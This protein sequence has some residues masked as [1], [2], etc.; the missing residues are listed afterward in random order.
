MKYFYLLLILF[1][2]SFVNAQNWQS[3]NYTLQINDDFKQESLSTQIPNLTEISKNISQNFEISKNMMSEI[4]GVE[5]ENYNSLIFEKA[6]NEAIETLL[7]KQSEIR[8]DIRKV[9]ILEAAWLKMNNLNPRLNTKM[10]ADIKEMKRI[11]LNSDS[12]IIRMIKFVKNL[13]ITDSNFI[14]I[15]KSSIDFNFDDKKYK[16]IQ[17]SINNEWTEYEKLN[18]TN[19]SSIPQISTIN[20][21]FN[22]TVSLLGAANLNIKGQYKLEVFVGNGAIDTFSTATILVPELSNYGIRLNGFKDLTK[23]FGINSDFHYHEKKSFNPHENVDFTFARIQSKLGIEYL[24]FKDILSVYGNVNFIIPVTNTEKYKEVFT[25]DNRDL[26]YYDLGLKLFVTPKGDLANT[27]G[28]G[29][30]VDLNFISTT[31][32]V[33]FYNGNSD[34]FIPNIK[35]GLQKNFR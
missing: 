18:K 10:F 30:F 13:E 23:R 5:N 15:E 28:V 9:D 22:P 21:K 12:E 33:K 16:E 20:K 31:E 4:K 7:F 11:L 14:P 27:S 19:K 1:N 24:V 17:T 26:R 2:Y 25:K 34:A 32:M 3:N 29:L 8:Q 6:R 35:F